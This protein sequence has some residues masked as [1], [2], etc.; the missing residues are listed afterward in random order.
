MRWQR[1]RSVASSADGRAVTSTSTVR[2]DGSSS[3][4]SSA[5]CADGVIFSAGAITATR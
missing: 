5:F 4:L 1:L 2:G 3:V